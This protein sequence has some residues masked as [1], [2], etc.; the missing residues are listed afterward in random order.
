MC[1]LLCVHVK[2]QWKTD[3]KTTKLFLKNPFIRVNSVYSTLSP[4]LS[5]W[6]SQSCVVDRLCNVIPNLQMQ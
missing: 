4:P 5:P 6:R 2:L 1:V 3:T